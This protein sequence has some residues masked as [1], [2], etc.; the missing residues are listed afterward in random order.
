M[1]GRTPCLR[2]LPYFESAPHPM[3]PILGLYPTHTTYPYCGI[4]QFKISTYPNRMH[5]S[6]EENVVDNPIN[7][8]PWVA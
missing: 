8:L 3:L 5:P 2:P 7:N 6:T 4:Q 1:R